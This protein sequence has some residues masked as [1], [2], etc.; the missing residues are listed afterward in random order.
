LECFL[1]LTDSKKQYLPFN[2]FFESF[3]DFLNFTLKPTFCFIALTFSFLNYQIVNDNDY[4]YH[5][6]VGSTTKKCV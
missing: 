1:L 3:F 2:F 5:Y 4:Q 6:V